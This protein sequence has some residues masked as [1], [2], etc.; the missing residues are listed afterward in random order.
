MTSAYT[1]NMKNFLS[2]NTL[3]VFT[4]LALAL[5]AAVATFVEN[6]F[7]TQV[8]RGYIYDALWYEVLLA[9]AAVNL[10]AVIFRT[11]LYKSL[12]KGLLHMSLIV[13]LIGAALTR[14]G[15]EE[16]RMHIREGASSNEYTSM[17]DDSIKELPFLLTLQNFEMERYPGSKSP[18]AFSSDVTVEDSQ[19]NVEF[20]YRI[21]MN[22]TLAHR[23][24]KF[25][26][27]SY[28]TDEMGTILTVNKD[29]GRLCT[30]I[31]Y[32]LLFLGLIINPLNPNSRLR[33]LLARINKHTLFLV[34]L[35]LS[36]AFHQLEA[37]EYEDK[38]FARFG[39]ETLH[40]SNEF[41]KLVVQSRMGRMKP[42]DTLSRE[43]VR[44]LSGK[45][46]LNG[47]AHNQIVLGM[48]FREDI[49]KKVQMI[50]VKTPRLRKIIGTNAEN[51]ASFNQFFE[52][53]RYLLAEDV[54]RAYALK[55]SQRGTFE[56][57]LIK[58]DERLNI[59]F[60]VYTGALFKVFPV[61]DDPNN[62][63]VDF[64]SIWRLSESM[65]EATIHLTIKRF[66][67]DG[68]AQN[69]AE[70]DAFVEKMDQYQRKYGSDVIPSR[71]AVGHE[72]LFNQLKLFPRL[73]IAYL[74]AGLVLL[75][76]GFWVLFHPVRF[77][78]WQTL[79][80]FIPLGLIVGTHTVALAA[81]WYIS[82]RAPLSNT[83]ETMMYI[84]YCASL[85]GVVLFRKQAFPMG[86]A[87]IMAGLFMFAGHLGSIDP[88][89]TNLVP[90]LK[91]F[92]LTVHVSVITA[93]YGFL[94]IGALLGAMTLILFIL[95]KGNR[96]A[97]E[98]SKLTDT[99]EAALII[100]LT[101][102]VI[103]NFLGGIWANESWGRYW[104]WDP[105]ET[106]AYISILIYALI[107]HFRLMTAVYSKYLFACLSLTAYSTILMTYY[108]VNYYLA[109]MH[110]YATGDPVPIPSWVYVS[111][112]VVAMLILSSYKYRDQ[113]GV[114]E[115]STDLG[116]DKD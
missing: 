23:G 111:I 60:M 43:I 89:I 103:G 93:S 115:V 108:G 62:Q 31:G 30:Y 2:S 69:Y 72:I 76:L 9:L 96:L 109:G 56:N 53:Q 59:A 67:D 32:F 40:T 44:K 94:G 63:W 99:N 79:C 65:P 26:Q 11:K 46:N 81:R 3:F 102:L 47:L 70:L 29:P 24:Y 48:F 57:D 54:E 18:S 101:L 52:G 95:N 86:A 22:H 88:E 42:M 116:K 91:S 87:F 106:W 10:L 112:G 27:T 16:G 1:N 110:S 64:K 28:D 41:S 36:V 97:L 20:D 61:I 104:G 58:V 21:Y 19:A 74:L 35:L 80:F 83:Y 4:F 13:I 45:E 5:G 105:K 34:P 14:Y 12:S 113:K 100:G 25:F 8:A 55:P 68:F 39:E 71:R 15:G 51:R 98:I 73:S 38:Y 6:D 84:A 85:G 7:G 75:G 90:V 78:K 37:G 92:W 77:S 49:W 107:T 114:N 50:K 66:M 82:G 33:I 17:E